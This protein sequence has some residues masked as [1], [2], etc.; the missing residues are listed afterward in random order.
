VL[1]WLST[2]LVETP[3][4]R[5]SW[6]TP[7]PALS[8]VL[9]LSLLVLPVGALYG[10]SQMLEARIDLAVAARDRLLADPALVVPAG[11]VVPAP[12][13]VRDD[14]PGE[15][16]SLC[17]QSI[18]GTA[19]ITCEHGDEDASI[20]IV[21][22]GGSH[23]S[24]WMRTLNAIGKQKGYRIVSMIKDACTFT[25]GRFQDRSCPTWNKRA[26]RAILDLKPD[27]VFAISTR[28]VRRNDV[29]DNET[30]PTGYQRAFAKLA[31]NRIPVL[32]LR[33]NP[34]FSYDV[35]QCVSAFA[36]EWTRCGRD[37]KDLLVEGSPTAGV[38][39]PNVYFVDLTDVYCSDGFC[40]A[41]KDGVLVYRDRHH[42]TG[43]F[44]Y[45]QQQRLA[46]EIEAALAK[47]GAAP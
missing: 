13:M 36:P 19:L 38:D 8:I 21:A 6:L 23:V 42:L 2:R 29:I 18:A 35:A 46:E 27:L 43:T 3:L 47:A 28:S 25:T 32:G 10:W 11:E 12:V 34:W 1:A 14:R 9:S 5:W 33:D 41:V 4:R 24:Q 30:V 45:L 20:T 26:M 39:A 37:M 44:A 7:R 17:D 22:V 16:V 31:D 15:R 40:P